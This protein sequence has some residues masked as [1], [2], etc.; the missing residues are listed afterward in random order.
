MGAS[1]DFSFR[2]NSPDD[3]HD[4]IHGDVF[5]KGLICMEFGTDGHL[6]VQPNVGSFSR[7]SNIQYGRH[8]SHFKLL[9][10]FCHDYSVTKS[11][12]FLGFSL[13]GSSH[14]IYVRI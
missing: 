11:D 1:S 13:L 12:R 5:S 3:R 10:K 6:D 14:R 8:D 4:V 9:S 7:S 2:K